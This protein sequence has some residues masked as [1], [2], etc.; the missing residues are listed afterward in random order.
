LGG[1]GG[2]PPPPLRG[3]PPRHPP[4]PLELCQKNVATVTCRPKR[5][6]TRIVPLPY[7]FLAPETNS[8]SQGEGR[9]MAKETI[10]TE[11]PL[12]ESAGYVRLALPLMSQYNVPITPRNYAVWYDYVSGKSRDLREAIDAMLSKAEQF[13][14]EINDVLYQRFC[15]EMDEGALVDLRNNLRQLL[16]DIFSQV[17]QLTEQAGEYETIVSKSVDKLSEGTSIQDIREVVDDII[18]ETKKIGHSGR[19][20]QEKLQE[21][22]DELESLKKEFEHAKAAALVDFLTGIANRKAFDMAIKGSVGETASDVEPLSLLLIDIDHFKRFNDEYG[23]IVGDEVLRLVA[24]KIKEN[25]RGRDFVARYGGEE[26]AVILPGTPILGA[27]KV[28]ENIRVSFSEGKLKRVKTSEYL[29]TIS[30]SVGAA[31]YR[32]GES[33]EALVNRSDQA[34][35]FAKDAGRDRVATE[36]DLT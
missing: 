30:I 1:G 21:A 29:G 7:T 4:P 31:P 20:T 34:L 3:P 23:H 10:D 16:I 25:V 8:Q 24:R 27:K 2:H 6:L 28:A 9:R 13:S 19:A 12:Q 22:T 14:D 35:Y 11:A 26:F 32:P 5:A 15:S 36:S 18:V 33:V 17:A